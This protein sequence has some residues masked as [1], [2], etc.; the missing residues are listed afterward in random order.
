MKPFALALVFPKVLTVGGSNVLEEPLLGFKGKAMLEIAMRFSTA[1]RNLG[2]KGDMEAT[3]DDYLAILMGW[4][5]S[6]FPPKIILN[7][8]ASVGL[9]KYHVL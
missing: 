5:V 9:S 4:L 7:I 1:T 3:L 8:T 2:I 6:H